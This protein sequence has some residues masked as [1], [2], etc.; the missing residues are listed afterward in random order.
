MQRHS[1]EH[2]LY[3]ELRSAINSKIAMTETMTLSRYV[4]WSNEIIA[5]PA[6]REEIDRELSERFRCRDPELNEFVTKFRNKSSDIC[7]SYLVYSSFWLLML[8]LVIR[9]GYGLKLAFSKVASHDW[10][11]IFTRELS[12]GVK[13]LQRETYGERFRLST[14]EETTFIAVCN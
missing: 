13:K 8:T 5:N 2:P 3:K 1:L 7:L 9:I 4:I 14:L 6:L 11:S 10:K 12:D